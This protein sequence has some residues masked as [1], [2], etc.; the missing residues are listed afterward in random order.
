MKQSYVYIVTNKCEGT[1]Y[2]GVTSDLLKRIYE[3]RTGAVDGFTK[4][5]NL[6]HLVYYEVFEDITAA[7]AR[8]KQLKKY[9]R[10]WKLDLIT[11]ANPHWQDLYESICV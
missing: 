1:L 10:Q 2:I 3:H 7:I 4:R 9:L 11:K 8:E 5:Y 6:H